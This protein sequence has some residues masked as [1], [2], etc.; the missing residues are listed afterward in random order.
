M[1]FKLQAKKTPFQRHKEEQ[2]LKRK[3]NLEGE[4][5]RGFISFLD[6]GSEK[7]LNLN[8]DLDPVLSHSAQNITSQREEEAAAKAYA[9]FVDD[10]GDGEEDPSGGGGGGGG[11]PFSRSRR[12]RR[13]DN[14]EKT[15]APSFVRGETI[16]PG[17]SSSATPGGAEEAARRKKR[18]RGK[19]R[20]GE[21]L[22]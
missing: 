14:N 11:G 21:R 4:K 9:D 2:E 13:G 7:K 22:R 15:N 20:G 19:R 3:V 1:N 10:F 5:E 16:I 6:V 17:S 18:K 8:L 12:Q